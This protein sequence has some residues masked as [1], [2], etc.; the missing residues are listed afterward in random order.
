M[1]RSIRVA[2]GLVDVSLPLHNH[3]HLMSAY[4]S[5]NVLRCHSYGTR[6][7]ITEPLKS[8]DLLKARVLQ[9]TRIN[10]WASIS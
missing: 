1:G 8:E 2:D 10:H 7:N 9:A 4:L 6:F 5:P 3:L